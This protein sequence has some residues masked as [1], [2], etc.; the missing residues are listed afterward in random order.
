MVAEVMITLRSGRERQEPF[1]VPK[2]EIDVEAA[3]VRLVD[4]EGVVLAQRSGPPCSSASST[5]SVI[6][7]TSVPSLTRSVKRTL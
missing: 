2:D 7:L 3:L 1:E 5:P 6:S 4:Y